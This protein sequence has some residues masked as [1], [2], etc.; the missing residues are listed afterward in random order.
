[1]DLFKRSDYVTAAHATR[2]YQALEA[3]SEKFERR[4]V[5]VHSAL[6]TLRG[7][8]HIH[9]RQ[10]AFGA[11]LREL[12]RMR[13]V[14]EEEALEIITASVAVAVTCLTVCELSLPNTDKAKDAVLRRF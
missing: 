6:A 12:Q 7:H 9:E 3:F 11:L 4:S 14:L 13:F 8:G 5:G 2:V 10:R 1:M